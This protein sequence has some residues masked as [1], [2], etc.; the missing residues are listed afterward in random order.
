MGVQEF[1][2]H[3]D[4]TTESL[5]LKGHDLPTHIIN[6]VQRLRFIYGRPDVPKA[7][8]EIAAEVDSELAS[9]QNDEDWN[10]AVQLLVKAGDPGAQSLPANDWYRLRRRLEI[11]KVKL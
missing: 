1:L 9:L 7:S 2:F 10:A 4:S 6:S 3:A 11:V 5:N 8:R